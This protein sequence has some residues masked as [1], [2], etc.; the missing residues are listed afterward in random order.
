[1][2]Y[3]HEDF[4]LTT[5]TA[6]RLYHEFV[7]A[8]PILDFHNHL[9]PG[10]IAG[11]R[12]F[13]NL[14]ELWL[15]HDHYK[16]R[17]LRA[18][19]VAEEWITGKAPPFEKFAAWAATVPKLL[20]SPLYHW[21]HLELQRL[22]GITDLLDPTTAR[23]IWEQTATLLT[24]PNFSSQGILKWFSVQALCTTDDPADELRHHERV[25]QSAPPFRMAPTFRP[26]KALAITHRELFVGWLDQ[27]SRVCG[28][29]I[30]R[31]DQLLVALRNR[32]A[33]FHGAGCRLSD[34][35]L[36]YCYAERCD[37]GEAAAIFDRARS[38]S[39]HVESDVRQ[40]RSFMMRFFGQLDAA[41]GWGMQLHLG[42]LRNNHSRLAGLLG[43][44]C[45]ADSIGDWPQASQLGRFLD[46]LDTA[47]SL[48]KMIV[49]CLNPADYYAVAT[50]LGNF[51]CD[52]GPAGKLQ[53]GP[54]WWF[55]DHVDG[56]RQHL[57]AVARTGVLG[58]FVGMTTDSR[59]FASLA[60]H[61]YFRRILCDWLGQE[62]GAG[63]MPNDLPLV[64]RVAQRISFANAQDWLTP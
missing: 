27:L 6:R 36:P 24:D 30:E 21:T 50:M 53:L 52:G 37:E 40:Y 12:S 41:A 43:A 13:D 18:A 54:A 29:A 8:E 23:D 9:D 32:H 61:D 58:T 2:T 39:L 20:G 4:L 51:Q 44:D 34:H 60:R 16:W 14:W 28:F 31:F 22:F 62:I 19:G 47:K 48:P 55:L 5:P 63:H 35:G 49:Y 15:Q 26:D 3:L 38:A 45:G 46:Q 7:S 10:D 59:S 42:A 64:G 17:A 11:N 1:M 25:R 33:E 57:S 56:I